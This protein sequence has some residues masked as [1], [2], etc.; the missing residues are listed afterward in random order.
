M[1]MNNEFTK[2]SKEFGEFSNYF[3]KYLNA[4]GT[5]EEAFM[6][7]TKKYKRLFKKAPYANCQSFLSDFYKSQYDSY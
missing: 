2:H 1:T 5:F 4:S 3:L 6:R 7:A